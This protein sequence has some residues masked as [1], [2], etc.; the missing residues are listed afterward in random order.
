MKRALY[1]VSGMHPGPYIISEKVVI[2]MLVLSCIRILRSSNNPVS[3]T[4]TLQIFDITG[5]DVCEIY[6]NIPVHTLIFYTKY[7]NTSVLLL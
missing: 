2:M 3:I 1:I 4:I 6:T 7:F 5:G